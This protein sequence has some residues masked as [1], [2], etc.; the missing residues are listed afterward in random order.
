MT[1]KSNWE[2]IFSSLIDLSNKV[3]NA[4]ICA[5]LNDFS[6]LKL[7]WGNYSPNCNKPTQKKLLELV[8]LSNGTPMAEIDGQIVWDAFLKKPAECNPLFLEEII[9]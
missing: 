5:V 4:V 2:L 9:F 7:V 3:A 8:T 1:S 6:N